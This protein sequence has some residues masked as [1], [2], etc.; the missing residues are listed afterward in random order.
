MIYNDDQRKI[1]NSNAQNIVVVAAA[2][3][4]KTACLAARTAKLL[5][6][7]AD[8]E[9]MALMTFTNMAAEEMSQRIGNHDGMYIGTIHGYAN[10]LLLRYGIDTSDV[11]GTENFDDLFELALDNP[12]CA[13]QIDY[14]LVDEAQDL[15]ELEYQFIFDV[16]K[17]KSFFMIGDHKQSIYG[18]R[19]SRPDLFLSLCEREDTTTYSLNKNYRNGYEI[20]QFAK[21]IIDKVGYL[22]I[23]NSYSAAT[24][25]GEVYERDFDADSIVRIVKRS[26]ENGFSNYRDW[27]ILC[28]FNEAADI[29]YQRFIDAG[30]PVETF[31]RAG[32][33]NTEMEVSLNNDTIKVL[34]IH[35]AKGLEANNV[36]VVGAKFYSDEEKRIS[37]VAATRA[38]NRLFWYNVKTKKK[39]IMSWE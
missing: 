19:G 5:N 8:P 33:S 9:R 38:K 30:L 25:N 3:T 13:K 1:I 11:I 28:R 16:I 34:T 23:D 27:F 32:M 20:L 15:T 39:K 6:D 22:Y 35:A 24:Q 2:A 18:F 12:Q 37:Y 29:M 26:I 21:R 7:G 14:L 10:Q 31:K 4:G 36:V 17:P